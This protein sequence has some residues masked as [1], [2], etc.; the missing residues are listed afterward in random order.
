MIVTASDVESLSR[1]LSLWEWGEYISEAFVVIACAGELVADLKVG[2]LTE[3]RKK[4]LQ[5]RSTVLLVAALSVSLLCLVRTNQLSGSVIGSLG[6]KA[7]EADRKAR[8][9]I[10]DSSTALSQTRDALTKAEKAQDSLGKAEAEANKA[11]T[12][13]SNAL[14]LARGA[15]QE[16]DSFEKDIA[17]AKGAA[18]K[19]EAKLADRTL[20]D[21]QVRSIAGK[22]RVFS[23]Q[24]Y[25]V[26]AY[27]DSKESLGI[28]NRIHSALLLAKWS[29]S[30]EG[31]KSMML[32]GEIGVLVWTHPEAGENTKKA[33]ASLIDALNA[34]G[35]EATPR[36]QNPQNPKSDMIAVNVGA[37]R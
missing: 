32:G 11:Q 20:T 1:S 30:D 36:L 24:A 2:W 33:A 16:A 3:E 25:T 4:H 28:A 37:K 22:L 17:A 15:R 6:D 9:A 14:T 18:S 26:T 10:T 8:E 31:S 7:E 27:W 12:A 21:E 34:E 13:S 5:R 35:I 19:A 23:G 29:Y